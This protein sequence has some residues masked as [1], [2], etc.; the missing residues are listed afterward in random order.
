MRGGLWQVELCKSQKIVLN[1]HLD[2]P[3][4][5]PLQDNV[6]HT[7]VLTPT[8]AKLCLPASSDCPC[9]AVQSIIRQLQASGAYVPKYLD[10]QEPTG[11]TPLIA[12]C[13]AGDYNCIDLVSA[14]SSA[15]IFALFYYETSPWMS[16]FLNDPRSHEQ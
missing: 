7:S 16:L 3:R 10:Y 2:S 12:A 9:L 14:G 5:V 13:K 15:Q 4:T 1:S 11:Y 8:Q 6:E